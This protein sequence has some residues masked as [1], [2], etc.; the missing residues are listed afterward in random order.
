MKARNATLAALGLALTGALVASAPAARAQATANTTGNI[1]T[2]VLLIVEENHTRAQMVTGMPYL[3]R[4][5]KTYMMYTNYTAV[6]HPS[7]PNYLAMGFGDTFNITADGQPS[8]YGQHSLSVFGA[9][10]AAGQTAKVY[11][12]DATKKCEPTNDP[13]GYY[14]VRHTIWPY[15][16]DERSL[17]PLS[18]V[19]AGTPQ[20]GPL[21]SDI[22]TET[23]PNVGVL[24]P[25][26]RHDAH[27]PYTMSQADAFLQSWIP[28]IMAGPDYQH[29]NLAIAITADEGN[30]ASQNVV[31]DLI[32][33]SITSPR[34]YAGPL[35]HYS[36]ARW[37]Y[38]MG[39]ATP[40][41]HAADPGVTS[42]GAPTFGTPP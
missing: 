9:A 32:H 11:A 2:K 41:R 38:Q 14:T 24:V 5:G 15:A 7:L 3:T 17:C 10:I 31:M 39:G 37:L 28:Q 30:T 8:K 13:N 29:G 20:G 34:T 33:P 16:L 26:L 23:L 4:L 1:P 21:A 36:L 40:Q 42:V 12:D 6:S 27:N 35:N 19:P 25:S 18:D 22:A